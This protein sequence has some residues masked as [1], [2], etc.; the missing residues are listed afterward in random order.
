MAT[1][2]T[3][4]A[5]ILKRLE[6]IQN[7]ISLQDTDDII[8]QSGKLQKISENTLEQGIKTEIEEILKLIQANAYGDAM[9]KISEFRQRFNTISKWT[10]P[11]I[12][13]LRAEILSL[14]SQISSLE[15]ELS[16][17]DKVI[18][19]FEVKQVEILGDII[20][21]IL[22]LKKNIAA[23]KIN[24][25]PLDNEAQKE[26]EEFEA[27]ERD[28]QGAYDETKNNPI[29]ELTQEEEQELKS[30]FRKVSKLTHP[31]LVDKKFERQAAELFD[32][33]KKAKDSNDIDA[34]KQI[35]AYLED[36]LPFSLKQDTIS[37]KAALKNEVIHLRD[38]ID[39][40][41]QKIN[42]TRNSETYKTIISIADLNKYF[43]ENKEK[44]QHELERL[45]TTKQ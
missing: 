25:D 28:Y 19:E 13:G 15:N 2:D 35:L 34:L 40:L 20:L 36:G 27:D 22:V 8:Y 42:S 30:I 7:V 16:D 31:D 26:F 23:K 6:V 10:D 32:K 41:K 18:H 44:L 14:S 43:S 11:E 9:H 12:Q 3:E 24:E 5:V 21:E 45:K 4:I 38:V 29:L 17:I 39:Q 1:T 37:E 33:A